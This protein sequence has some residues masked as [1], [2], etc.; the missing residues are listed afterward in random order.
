MTGPGVRYDVAAGR[1]SA[2]Q[3][4]GLQAATSCLAEGLLG[5]TYSDARSDPA[6]G[7]GYFYLTRADDVCGNGTFGSAS[8]DALTCP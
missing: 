1:L 4:S 2:L 5:T 3:T 7:D 8:V 6:P